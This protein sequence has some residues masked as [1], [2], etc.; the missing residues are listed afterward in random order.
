MKSAFC[1]SLLRLALLSLALSVTALAQADSLDEG[2]AT[3]PDSAK[4]RTWWHWVSGNVSSEGITADLQAM[5]KIGLGGAQIFTVDQSEVKGPVVFLSPEWRKLMHQALTEGADLHFEMAMEGCDGWS[6]SGGHWVTP[7]QAMQ[8]VV[9]SE[10]Y[11]DGGQKISLALPQPET[12]DK[13]YEDIAL[14]AF[15]T[16]TGDGAA[17]PSAVTSSDASAPPATAPPTDKNPVHVTVTDSAPTG[18]V[19]FA[20]AEPVTFG[21]L[22]LTTRAFPKHSK[23]NLEASDDG[24]TY[25]QISSLWVQGHFSFSPVTAKY[26]RI[27]FDTVQRAAKI[28][29]DEVALSGPRFS[30]VRERTGLAVSTNLPFQEAAFT[31]DQM[32]DPKALVDLTGKTE[33]DA[34]AGKWTIVRMGHT[35]TGATTHP[36][37]SPGLECDKMSAAAVKSHI[38]NLFGPVWQDS[39]SLTGTTLRYILLDSWEAG[40]ENWTPLLR[41][42][43]KKRHGYD[44]WPWLPALTGRVV[45]NTDATDRFLWDYRRTL[46]DLVAENHYGTFQDEAHAHKMGL[47]SEAPGI[48]SPTVADGLQCKGRTDIPMG[49]F[50]VDQTGES[51]VDDPREA[52]TAAHIYG[53]NIAAT[54]SFT[55][56]PGVAAWRNDPYSL[57]ME[58]D[59]EF[60]LGVNRFIFHRYAHQPWMDRVP[61]MSMGPWGINFERTNTWWD[62]GSAWIS[63]LSRCQY[64]LQEGRFA[65]DL[66]YFYG[67]SA[68]IYFNHSSLLPKVPTGYDYDACDAEILLN[69]MSVEDGQIV[70]KSGMRYRVLVLPA[71]DRMTLPVLQKVAALVQAGAT[72]YGPLPAKSP[73]LANYPDED[74]QLEKL[75]GEV[76]GDCDG[77][78]VKEHAYGKGRIVWGKALTDILG[79]APDFTSSQPAVLDIHRTMPDAEIYFVSNQV[80]FARDVECTFRVDGKTPELW[81]PDTGKI[82]LPALYHQQGGLTA[83]PI[84]FDPAGSVFVIFRHPAADS[85]ASLTLDGAPFGQAPP[86]KVAVQSAFYGPATDPAHGADVKDKVQSM[87]DQGQM[88]IPAS[89]GALAKSD[90]APMVPKALTMTYTV[91]GKAKSGTV[92]EG[93]SLMVETQSDTQQLFRLDRHAN[94]DV[95]LETQQGGHYEAK[96][97]ANTALAAVIPPLPKPVDVTGPWHLTFPPKRGAPDKAT[98]PTLVSWTESPVDGI[99]YFSGTAT[100][101]TDVTIP[102]EFLGAGRHAYLDLGDVKNLAEVTLNGKSLGILWKAP[103]R[104]DVSSAAVAGANHL[105]V[106]ITN[107]WPN[108]LIGDS[109]LPKEQQI[110]WASVSLYKPD[111]PLLPSGLLGPVVVIPT[112]EAVLR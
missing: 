51:N 64:L 105:E 86:V 41:E 103:F 71:T 110:T 38:E 75:A 67:E 21:S 15:P 50:W 37:T 82:E 24:T 32:I 109:K 29:F 4:P 12:N 31:A 48:G 94:G 30:G 59:K 35:C 44:L 106:K 9:W 88:L 10:S 85:L 17:A 97:A 102:A 56:T 90:P 92:K 61:G 80:N 68:P 54:E 27:S 19:Q 69:Q 34:P 47:T 76:W 39:G 83:V 96:T 63:Y 98:F 112:A 74:A 107:L 55:S 73:S 20:Y 25:R 49:E 42:E 66:L 77:R 108:R 57:K 70:L 104:V 62:E 72:V 99:K 89:T 13:Y 5:K 91:N 14:F 3:P 95:V 36:S 53:Q 46:A 8:K 65:A 60:C 11:V 33:W 87:I 18:W 7:A 6:E 45:M 52:A 84:H 40:C 93:D 1:P 16:L 43:F 2:F 28:E 22:E 101:R 81:H 23:L 79:V 111:S 78:K 100:Y 26:F 58:G